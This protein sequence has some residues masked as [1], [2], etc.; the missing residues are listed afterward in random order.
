[1]K[2]RFPSETD[3]LAAAAKLGC[4]VAAILAV[5]RVEAAAEGGFLPSEEPLVLFE[6][7]LFHRFTQGAWDASH[8]GVSNPQPGGY[9]SIGSQH[10]RLQEASE[11][12]REAALRAASWGLFQILGN[13]WAACGYPNLQAFVNAMYRSVAD[14]LRAF[15]GFVAA[16]AALLAALRRRDW[17]SFARGY[18]GPDY[19]RNRY[20]EKLAAGY[21]SA[22]RASAG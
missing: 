6:R 16:D 19:R 3:Y 17:P 4:E 14:H 22:S 13:N 1:V 11:L 12:D 10:A 9:G 21:A 5:A 18:N 20:D 2:A 8:P 15:C 7:H